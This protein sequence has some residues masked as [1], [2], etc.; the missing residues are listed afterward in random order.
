M[1]GHEHDTSREIQSRTELGGKV[2]A[3][4][5]YDH[6]DVNAALAKVKS[7]EA[8]AVV[9]FAGTTRNSFQSKVVLDL[10][11]SAYGPLALQSMLD[12][13]KKIHEAH[14]LTAINIVHRLGRVPIG[15][16]SILIC[17]SAPHRT[18]A[19]RAGEEALEKIKDR[20]EI[21]KLERFKEGDGEAIWKANRD[22]AA[23]QKIDT[24]G[25]R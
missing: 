24:A 10:E 14:S 23:G 12:I 1:N 4:L 18:A 15:E 11:Y 17:L 21:W 2:T 20:V 25:T 7:P 19:W 5:T 16:E 8:G 22:G 3:S 6:L 13:A 9:M